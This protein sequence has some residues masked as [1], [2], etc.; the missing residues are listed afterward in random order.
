MKHPTLL[1]DTATRH[2]YPTLL[3]D[4]AT[5][6]A[7]DILLDY[8]LYKSICSVWNSSSSSSYSEWKYWI[9]H[10]HDLVKKMCVLQRNGIESRGKGDGGFTKIVVGSIYTRLHHPSTTHFAIILNTRA[11]SLLF[12]HGECATSS[13]IFCH[14][15]L[16][17]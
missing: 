9:L 2:C 3:P 16:S 5:G 13:N 14:Q 1:P 6:Q 8:S 7:L 4:T 17:T 15:R 10:M 11:C 12:N